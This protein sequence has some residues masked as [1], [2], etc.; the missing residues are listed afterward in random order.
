MKGFPK[1]VTKQIT[2]KILR[3]MSNSIYKFSGKDG[4]LNT[5]FFADIKIR[6]KNVPVVI[7]KYHHQIDEDYNNI[8]LFINN[9]EITVDLGDIIYKNND[10]NFSIIEIKDNIKNNNVNC[11]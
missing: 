8:N 6:D 9:K 5:C 1:P 7:I 3:Q 10:Y 2:E 11:I 4:K